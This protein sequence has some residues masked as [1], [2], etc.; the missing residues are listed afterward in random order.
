MLWPSGTGFA[1]PSLTFLRSPGQAAIDTHRKTFR[2]RQQAL[3]GGQAWH[4]LSQAIW[5]GAAKPGWP[6]T[7]ANVQ[8]GKHNLF[9]ANFREYS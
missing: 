2:T 4:I 9:E 7:K 8:D 1:T 5:Q 6:M 3:S